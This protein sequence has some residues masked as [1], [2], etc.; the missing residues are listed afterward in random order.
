MDIHCGKSLITIITIYKILYF[1]INGTEESDR[2]GRLINHSKK[3]SNCI[4]KVIIMGGK[5]RLYFVAKCVIVAGSEILYD[6]GE[7]DPETLRC[8]PWLTE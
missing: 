4:P 8:L 3:K 1:S 5:P 2:M 7:R 6:Y